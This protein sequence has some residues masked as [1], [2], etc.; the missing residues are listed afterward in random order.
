MS[1]LTDTF[2]EAASPRAGRPERRIGQSEGTPRHCP[3]VTVRL[4]EA[5][6]ARLVELADGMA[7]STYIRAAA[8]NEDLS[9]R[10]RRSL[11]PMTDQKAIAQVLGLL[12]Q[13]RI[14]NN[15]NQLAYQA[16]IGALQMDDQALAQ[17]EE[18]YRHIV[19]MRGL[20]LQAL[21]GRS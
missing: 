21:D 19:A 20:L 10:K 6:H 5:D 16:N 7:L 1:G 2:S 14:A 8:L 15:L 18:A 3:R 17:V 12:G 4:S 13:S 9:K 11:S